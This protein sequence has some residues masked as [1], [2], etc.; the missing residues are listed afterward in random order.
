VAE[1][2]VGGDRRGVVWV[3]EIEREVGDAEMGVV[4]V[5]ALVV[6]VSS[7]EYPG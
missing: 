1:M 2:V 6:T 3:P 4:W 7:S 5:L